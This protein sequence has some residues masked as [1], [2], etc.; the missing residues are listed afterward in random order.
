MSIDIGSKLDK[1]QKNV[2]AVKKLDNEFKDSNFDWTLLLNQDEKEISI[3]WLLFAIAGYLMSCSAVNWFGVP[4]EKLYNLLFIIGCMS[5]I[6][7][8]ISVHLKIKNNTSTILVGIVS[9]L[10]FL[11]AA[12]LA[13]PEQ[14]AN[15]IRSEIERHIE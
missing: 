10:C 8:I 3:G 4:G 6:W 7:L 5:W 12:G 14:T 2:T 11:V 1:I 13:T 15:D 9:F